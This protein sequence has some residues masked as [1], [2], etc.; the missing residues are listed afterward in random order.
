MVP[1]TLRQC[2]Y[3]LA[4]A[5]HGGIAQAARALS[6]S[7]PSVA[8]GL[9]TLE[10]LTGLRLFERHHA[11]GTEL[12]AQG[13]QFRRHVE[14]LVEHARQVAREAEAIAA[15]TSGEL[16]LGCFTTIAAFYLPGLLKAH[17]AAHPGIRISAAE[18]ALDRLARGVAQGNLDAC[19]TYTIGDELAPLNVVRLAT[20]PPAVLLPAGHPK[21][22]AA[23]VALAELAGEPY[24]MFDAPGSREYFTGLLE[25]AGAAPAIGYAA[26]SLEGVRTAVANGFGFSV[27]A[28]RPRHDETYDGKRV[29]VVPVSDPIPA[30]DIVAATR[31]PEPSGIVARF[32]A[33]AREHFAANPD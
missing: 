6:V 14:G 4:V 29:A 20:V 13:K 7:Q 11:R 27:V 28:L 26:G 25:A 5:E 16:R 24:V 30:L 8:Q 10:A 21:A 18:M 33:L 15:Q 3:F 19:L 2:R 17:R 12:T 22:G 9:E 1:Y 23:S 32:I 31:A